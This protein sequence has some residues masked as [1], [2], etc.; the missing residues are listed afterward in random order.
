MK[1]FMKDCGYYHVVT[2][3]DRKT[4]RCWKCGKIVA[5]PSIDIEVSSPGKG[6][7]HGDEGAGKS[8][9]IMRGITKHVHEL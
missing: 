5:S 3:K 6:G 1:P 2:W 8:P 9:C 4:G 7:D